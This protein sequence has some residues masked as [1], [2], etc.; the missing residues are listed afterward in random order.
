[1][2]DLSYLSVFLPTFLPVSAVASENVAHAAEAV[3]HEVSLGVTLLFGG[4]LLAMVICLALEEKLHAKKS[5]IVGV[6]AVI[7]I[8]LATVMGII[9]V[10][11]PVMLG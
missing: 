1:M 2:F 8:L 3:S 4:I 6:F 5:V 11:E 7:S 10:S 9:P